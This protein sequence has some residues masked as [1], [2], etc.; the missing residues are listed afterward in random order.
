VR[1]NNQSCVLR[2]EAP[3]ARVLFTGDIERPAEREL[4]M[5]APALLPGR[6]IVL[7]TEARPRRRR[8]S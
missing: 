4:L 7:T 3:A 2:V 1:A 5:R 8:S 6:T